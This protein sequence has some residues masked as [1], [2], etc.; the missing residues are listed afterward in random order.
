MAARHN[1]IGV[2]MV[3]AILACAF[4]GIAIAGQV[5]DYEFVTVTRG[6]GAAEPPWEG[7]AGRLI[8]LAVAAVPEPVLRDWLLDGR[9]VGGGEVYD[10]LRTIAARRAA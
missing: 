10:A 4:V 2:L 8:A 6:T 9:T 1:L 5:G 3:L 7:Q